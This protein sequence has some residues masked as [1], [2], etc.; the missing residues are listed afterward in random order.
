[1]QQIRKLMK[2]LHKRP[3]TDHVDQTPQ[4]FPQGKLGS[5]EQ[6][7]QQIKDAFKDCNDVNHQELP[8]GMVLTDSPAF[9]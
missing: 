9:V 2:K 4:S 6:N 5:Y 7:V 8:A 1:M 3:S